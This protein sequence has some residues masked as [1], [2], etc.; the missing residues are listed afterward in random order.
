MNAR[1]ALS[2]LLPFLALALQWLLWPW[3]AP[4]VWF[5]FF[6]TVF[7]SA[8]LGGL[9]GGLASTVLSAGM[10]WYFFIPP[11][12][13]WAVD[14]P[15]NLYS[16]GL[17]VIMGYL[18]S[19]TQARL[20]RAQRNTETALAETRIANER[21]TLLYQKTLELDELKS[22]FFANVSHELRTPLTLIMSPLA[23]R[24]AATGLSPEQRREDEMMLRNA[25][26]L[27][28]H[29]SDLLDAAKLESGHMVV[30]YAR[31]ELTG[32]VRAMASQFDSLAREKNIAYRI[33][34]PSPLA[35]EVDGE[36]LQRILLNLLSNAFKFTPEGGCIAVRLRAA[37]S[38]AV[39]EVQDNGPGVPA[40]LREAAFERFRQL[41]GGAQRRFGG[42][43]LGLAIVKEFAE[44]HGGSASVDEAA[45]GGALFVIRLPLHAPASAVIQDTA[46][47]LDPLIDHQVV[48]ELRLP[49]LNP[50]YPSATQPG[51]NAALVLVVEDNAD[52]N[53]F[54]ADALSPH[55][56]VACAFDGRQGLER[57]LALQPD[58]ILSDV[59]MPLLSGDQMV[60]A[61]RRQ[62]EMLDVPIVM[63][64]AKAD[65]D[66]RVRLLK[67][68]VQD[69]LNKPFAVEELL[70]RVGGLIGEYRRSKARLRESEERLRLFIEHAP[71]ALAMFDC[72]MRYLAVSRRWMD[73][74]FLG[75]RDIIGCSHYEIFPEITERWKAVHRRGMAGEVVRAE[76]DCFERADGAVQWLRWEVRPWRTADGAVGGI[77][78][79]SK[80]IT[81]YRQA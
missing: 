10:V 39:I 34:A 73:D 45:G 33:D 17:F 63:L 32:L 1:L 76:A 57:A 65:D 25:W 16:V 21:I 12:L 35:A 13:S 24:L 23:R 2:V 75:D 36:K 74:Y 40:N 4:F 20:R 77:V 81:R 8:R 48:N 67:E 3:I 46:S 14:N 54:I 47:R 19:D 60:Q 27:Y 11:Q 52:M 61:L 56:R 42:T 31:V 6:P 49:A 26:L 64:T 55:Y 69:Y 51:A 15:A 9:W 5:L 78:I 18:F 41:E 79:F 53:A 58:L 28:R 43:G 22:Q 59:M 37:A 62:P 7:F 71:A 50:V 66:L 38:Q 70:A 29:V 72:D 30:D 44:L 80:D 68:G